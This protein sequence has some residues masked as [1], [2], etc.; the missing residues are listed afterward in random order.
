M[1]RIKSGKKRSSPS[2]AHMN[3]AVKAV[4]ENNSSLRE[5]TDEYGISKSEIWRS[6]QKAG[7]PD[8]IFNYQQNLKRTKYLP[9]MKKSYCQCI[10]KKCTNY[11]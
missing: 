3:A 4:L 1:S 9:P 11:Q 8:K 2:V 5:A 6:V 7:A 10:L